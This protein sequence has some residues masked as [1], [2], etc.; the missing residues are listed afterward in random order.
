MPAPGSSHALVIP[1]AVG[2]EEELILSGETIGAE[3]DRF[4]DSS[5]YRAVAVVHGRGQ[6]APNAFDLAKRR[7]NSKCGV[8]WV[9]DP[10]FLPYLGGQNAELFQELLEP[11]PNYV[12]TFFSVL[13]EEVTGQLH[14]LQLRSG[15]VDA[16]YAEA[17]QG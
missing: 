6:Q 3:L 13:R 8:V 15:D 2:S 10:D 12:M 14:W 4:L 7:R 11:V 17:E 1:S 16:Q 9:T 5:K